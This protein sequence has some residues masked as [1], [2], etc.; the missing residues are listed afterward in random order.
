M[1]FVLGTCALGILDPSA[2]VGQ[3]SQASSDGYTVNM[4]FTVASIVPSS[5]SCPFGYNYNVAV[6]Y[7]VSFS[8]TNIPASLYTLQ[9]TVTCGGTQHFFNLPNGGGTGTVTSVSN[10]YRNASDCNTAT[11]ASL[12]CTD[13]DIQI[14]GSGL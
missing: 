11:P 4:S 10:P 9:G 2:L 1:L 7:A 14:S 5:N 8:G 12:G 6:D 3:C 13:V